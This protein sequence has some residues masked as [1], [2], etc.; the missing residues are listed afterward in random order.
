MIFLALLI[1]MSCLIAFLLYLVKGRW[2][3]VRLAMRIGLIITLF[4]SGLSHLVVGGWSEFISHCTLKDCLFVPE[5]DP[6]FRLIDAV[7]LIPR[8]LVPVSGAIVAAGFVWRLLSG[9]TSP[10]IPTVFF[11]SYLS[12]DMSGPWILRIAD[13]LILFWVLHVSGLSA[14]LK[15]RLGS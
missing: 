9:A 5:S 8:V 13:L 12:A 14:L 15:R 11:D 4:V 7:L 3:E 2:G 10:L 6:I 1:L